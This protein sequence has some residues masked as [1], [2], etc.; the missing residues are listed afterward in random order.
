[1]WADNTCKIGNENEGTGSKNDLLVI[2]YQ[3][4]LK[5]N[6]LFRVYPGNMQYLSYIDTER[7]SKEDEPDVVACSLICT[8][9]HTPVA[10]I[11]LIRIILSLFD[12]YLR[13]IEG[14]LH[15]YLSKF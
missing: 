15:F 3:Q 13:K 8:T 9:F 7:G 5:P 4:I 6:V 10:F 1:M 12:L 2:L 11:L 14:T